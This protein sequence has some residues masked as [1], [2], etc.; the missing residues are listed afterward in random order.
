[1]RPQDYKHIKA[2]GIMMHSHNY[3]IVAEQEQAA[4]DNAPLDAIFKREDGWHTFAGTTNPET[5]T[6][7][8]RIL[9]ET[10]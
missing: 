4:L 3:Y 8:N 6:L 10:K 7:I 1:M 9:K 5:I 2:W